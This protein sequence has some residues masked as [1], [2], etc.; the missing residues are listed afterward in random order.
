MWV[1]ADMLEISLNGKKTLTNC[2]TAFE[3]RDKEFS[4]GS[5]VIVNGYQISEDTIINNNDNIFIIQKGV[6]PP[7]EQLELMICARHTPKVYDKMKNATVGI[8]GLGGLGSNIAISLARMGI[9]HLILI[10]FDIVEPS[11]LNRQSY[12]INHLGMLKCIAM[13][14]QIE[15]I[16]PF[17]KVTAVNEYLT[18]NNACLILKDCDIICEAFDNPNCKAM[19]V[20]EILEKLPDTPLVCSSGMAGY[21]SSNTIRTTNP[22]KNLYICGDGENGAEIGRGLM[23]PRVQICAGHQA[24]MA[25]RL[26]LN[27]KDC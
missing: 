27:I 14:S 26:L 13:K 9:G 18:E 4:N 17:I 1:A 22:I 6:M 7:K 11:N 21:E 3:L 8:A 12:Y 16:N 5:I 15:Q 24:N 23:A 25:V 2:K 19:L 20:N 10:D